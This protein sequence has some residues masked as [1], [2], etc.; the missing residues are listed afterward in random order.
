MSTAAATAEASPPEAGAQLGDR[1]FEL[2]QRLF[3]LCRS[4][5]GPGV[6]DWFEHPRADLGGVTPAAALDDPD[7]LELLIG[8]AAASRGNIAA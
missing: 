6:V 2:M 5:T 7:M 8:A 1:A 3:G 4:L